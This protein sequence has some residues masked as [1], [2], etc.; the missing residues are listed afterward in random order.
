VQQKSQV[1]MIDGVVGK[2][3][4][5]ASGLSE[6]KKGLAVICHPHTLY[7]GTMD[8]KVVVTVEKAL[9]QQGF[10]TVC[11]NFRGAGKSEGAYDE[12]KGEQADLAVVVTWAKEQMDE[13]AHLLLAGFSFGSFV[14]TQ[15]HEDLQADAL[16]LVAPPVSLYDFSPLQPKVPWH[17]IQGGEDEVI[18]AQAVLDW[19]R[20]QPNQPDLYWRGQASHFFHRQLVWLRGVVSVAVNDFH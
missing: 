18:E 9:Q 2:L 4:V 16:L 8:N 11:F 14:A 17:V 15:A 1:Q 12:G 10:A 5:R 13:T 3:E 7:G 20:K 19:V 6:N